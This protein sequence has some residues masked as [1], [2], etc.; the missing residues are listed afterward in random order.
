MDVTKLNVKFF[1]FLLL[2]CHQICH[3]TLEESGFSQPKQTDK[4]VPV[5]DC[6][7]SSV[8]TER[9]HVEFSSSVID[10]GE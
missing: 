4:K 8:P 2:L 9:I 3:V 10:N 5:V 6:A 1:L 7:N